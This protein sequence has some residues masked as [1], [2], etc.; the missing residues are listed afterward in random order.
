MIYLYGFVRPDT[1]P[2]P[3]VLADLAGVT[4][5]VCHAQMD[6]GW[7][8][9]G[10]SHEAELLPKRRHLLAHTRV[11]EAL[12]LD[13]AV[14][15]MRFGLVAA[16]IDAVAALAARN[17]DALAASFARIDGCVE[18]GLRLS[19]DRDAALSATLAA[20]P[21]L[22]RRH[23]V[24]SAQRP[25]PH[26]EAAEFG[27]QL[28]EALDRRRAAAQRAVVADLKPHLSEYALRAPSSDVEVLSIAAL[29][30]SAQQTDLTEKVVA[31]A[32]EVASFATGAEPQVQIVGP[33]PPFSF[34]DLRLVPAHADAA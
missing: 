3:A 11:L 9:Y 22:A 26:F 28:A 17:A 2:D 23:K 30:P 4:G 19:F 16:D 24:L 14:L 33:V 8:I 12:G 20:A 25:A 34:V 13:G 18:L 7:L 15:P 21:D 27:R 5:P 6:Q 32:D 29:V 1:P 10:P 31:A